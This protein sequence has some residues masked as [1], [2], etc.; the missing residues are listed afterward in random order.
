MSLQDQKAGGGSGETHPKPDES[1]T[2]RDQNAPI[3][4]LDDPRHVPGTAF[5]WRG[6]PLAPGD[7]IAEDI[8]ELIGQ[9]AQMHV[10]A[11]RAIE[12]RDVA[13]RC[14]LKYGGKGM[15]RIVAE[16]TGLS[17]QAVYQIRDRGGADR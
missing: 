14:A 15:A 17:T 12:L 11:A 6:G 2:I 3:V 10:A 1:M 4:E 8:E 16:K 13:I 5:I 7:N 9:A